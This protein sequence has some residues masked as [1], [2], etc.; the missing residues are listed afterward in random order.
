MHVPAPRRALATLALLSA[1][2][3]VAAGCGS[4]DDSKDSGSSAE[5]KKTEL[6]VYSGREKELV[7]PL[8]E[9]FEETHDDID[10]KVRYA[11][12]P[13]MA[14]QL[15]EEGD[16]SPADVFYSQDAGA[17]GAVEPLLQQLP[18]EL[19][20]KVAPKYR[21]SEERWVGVTGRI[22]TLVYTWSRKRTCPRACTT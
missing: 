22:R 20:D 12:S 10:L 18:A 13:A 5:S 3:F 17:I 9:Q 1:A 6:V 21:D 11:D 19:L 14:A 2:T 15:Q 8:Y 4:D 7:E 16:N